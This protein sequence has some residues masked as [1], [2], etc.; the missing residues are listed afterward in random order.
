MALEIFSKKF[1]D[2]ASKIYKAS[3]ATEL[4]KMGASPIICVWFVLAI[5]VLGSETLSRDLYRR[6]DDDLR[7]AKMSGQSNEFVFFGIYASSLAINATV[8]FLRPMPR[9]LSTIFRSLFS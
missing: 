2:S 9:P 4:N 8:Y 3:L 1:M 6:I 5:E 7:N